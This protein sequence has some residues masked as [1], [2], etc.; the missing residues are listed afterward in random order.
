MHVLLYSFLLLVLLFSPN[1]QAVEVLV[2]P[3]GDGFV[4]AVGWEAAAVLACAAIVAWRRNLALGL[5]VAVALIAILRAA[6][7]A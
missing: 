5:L 1:A 3:A 4:L 6:G 7:I 2:R